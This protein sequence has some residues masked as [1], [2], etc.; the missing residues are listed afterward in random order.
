MSI[1]QRVRGLRRR[2]SSEPQ[3]PPSK[4]VVGLGN[5]GARYV[6]TRHNIGFRIVE[7]LAE[8]HAAH[9]RLD[10]ALAAR[11]AWIEL[12]GPL[13]EQPAQTI[14]LLA[15]QTFMNRSGES[16]LAAFDRW[17]DL[18]PRSDLI[19]VHDDLDLPTGR[20]R[21]RPRGGAGGHNG[22]GDILE[23]LA[24][25]DVARLRFGIGHPGDAGAVLDWVLGPFTP[26]EEA[27][28][29]PAAIDRAADALEGALQ[30]GVVSAMGRFNAATEPRPAP[31]A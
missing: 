16:V 11:L 9:W 27:E 10:E 21:L 28:I 23:R 12:P 31:S 29:L 22:I 17:P 26:A 25:Q 6:R 1:L 20:I 8:R 24:S 2:A 4:L 14:A 30:E 13:P 5:P 19:V 15:P 7:R 3:A 18:D